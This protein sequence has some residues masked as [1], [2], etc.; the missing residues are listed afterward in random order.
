MTPTRMSIVAV[1]AL[2]TGLLSGCHARKA[3]PEDTVVAGE[4][5]GTA[6][7]THTTPSDT[8]LA[9]LKANFQKVHFEFDEAT[10]TPDARAA[11]EANAKI[12]MKYSQV[13]VQVE[14]HTDHFGSEEYNLALGQRRAE[15]VHRYLLDM[16]V[17]ATKLTLISYGKEKA[18]VGEGSKSAEA[19]NRRAEFVVL[20]GADVAGSSTA[21]PGVDV[22]VHTTGG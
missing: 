11:L 5:S 3:G 4:Q 19:P 10:L 20:A 17:S 9:A 2:S 6:R 18:L 13:H 14:G 22:T 8:D 16:G 15:T 12:L 1:A 7:N 21:Q